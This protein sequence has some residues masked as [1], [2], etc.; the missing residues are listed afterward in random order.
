MSPATSK[1]G[2]STTG[3]GRT[4]R[5]AGPTTSDAARALSWGSDAVL[6]VTLAAPDA[7]LRVEVANVAA[8]ALLAIDA[9]ASELD[10]D[11]TPELAPLVSCLRDAATGERGT[12][13]QV[14]LRSA[15]GELVVVDVQAEV[16]A[17]PPGADRRVLAVVR[18]A[19]HETPA[20]GAPPVVGMFRTELGLGAVFVDDA[21]LALLGLSHEQALGQ[22]WIDALHP[23]DRARVAD[24]LDRADAPDE[25]VCLEFRLLRGGADEPAARIRAVPVRGDDGLLMGYLA[26]IEDITDEHRD[27]EAGARLTELADALDEWITIADADMHLRYANPAARRGLALPGLDALSDVS[28]AAM[29]VTESRPTI[30]RELADAFAETNMWSG[31]LELRALDDRVVDVDCTIVAHRTPEGTVAHYS[32]LGRDVTTFRAIERALRESEERFRL[33]AD[34]SPA[35]IYFMIERGLVN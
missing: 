27:R 33:I 31:G 10:A 35:G 16:L 3:S 11:V 18:L 6:L 20:V 15:S 12:R 14:A 4:E 32:L 5:L 17:R 9:A 13:A 23:D 25:A 1:D 21:M 30:A 29:V 8:R 2:E 19:E 7:P 34:S 28:L 24:A 22:G 26:S